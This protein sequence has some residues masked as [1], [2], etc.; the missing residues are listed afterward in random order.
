MKGHAVA[1]EHEKQGETTPEPS[2]PPGGEGGAPGEA[3][4]GD[5]AKTYDEAYVKDL[6]D[7][8]A[9]HRVKAKRA[10]EAEHRLHELAI[11][12]AVE[13]IL[14]DPT[15]LGWTEE[16]A[17]ENGWPDP[18]KIRAAAEELV[19]RKPHLGR[20]SGDVGQ[21]RHSQADDAVS[22]STLLKAGA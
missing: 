15:D 9:A 19:N 5:Q 13:G 10:E 16:Y 3:S 14:T 22:L 7:E 18:D 8:A 12:Q 21:G 6:R 20:P 11:A 4:G 2:T 17:D 1:T